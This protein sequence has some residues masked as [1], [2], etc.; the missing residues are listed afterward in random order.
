MATMVASFNCN[1]TAW[2]D[3]TGVV[4]R[5]DND[6]PWT[7]AVDTDGDDEDGGGFPPSLVELLSYIRRTIQCKRITLW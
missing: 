2:V 5:V 1:Q 3:H 4:W 6:H 7:A